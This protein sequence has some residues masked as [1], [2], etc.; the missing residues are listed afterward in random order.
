MKKMAYTFITYFFTKF[1]NNI[2]ISKHSIY[3][4]TNLEISKILLTINIYALKVEDCELEIR[5]LNNQLK[6]SNK[7]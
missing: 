2:R 4:E 7:L 6:L 3:L 5:I 1:H